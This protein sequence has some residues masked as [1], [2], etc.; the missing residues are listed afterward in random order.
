MQN[1]CCCT[2]P[3]LLYKTTAVIQDHR[4]YTKPPL[5]Y[6]TSAVVQNLRC[7]T[8]PPLLYKTTAVVQNLRCCTRPPLLYKTTGDFDGSSSK[9][10]LYMKPGLNPT[11]YRLGRLESRIIVSNLA[12]KVL[13]ASSSI[14]VVKDFGDFIFRRILNENLARKRVVSSEV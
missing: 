7:C 8:K 6:K 12:N 11:S 5:L 4:C 10:V 14:V 3:P 9:P 13:E 2:R 1:F